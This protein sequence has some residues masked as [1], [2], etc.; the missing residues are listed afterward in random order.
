M[1]WPSST[2]KTCESRQPDL[3]PVA[4]A[5]KVVRRPHTVARPCPCC[6]GSLVIEDESSGR[7]RQGDSRMTGCGG[8]R[9]SHSSPATAFACRRSGPSYV[10]P[11]TGIASNKWR[12]L[13]NRLRHRKR[14]SLRTARSTRPPFYPR[15]CAASK[16]QWFGS[17][18][19]ASWSGCGPGRVR[20][21]SELKA[22]RRLR[23]FWSLPT[24]SWRCPRRGKQW[25]YRP[26]RR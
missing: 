23:W 1:S 18:T 15:P 9:G 3:F 13:T 22:A 2:T 6:A 25:R 7:S 24:P 5:L 12:L 20:Q 26:P 14:R 21:S 17:A 10:L 4:L 8:P 19:A 16:Q 11:A